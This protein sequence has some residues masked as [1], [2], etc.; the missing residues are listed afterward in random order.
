MTTVFGFGTPN[1]KERLRCWARNRHAHS[2][3][4]GTECMLNGGIVCLSRTCQFRIG[5]Q[6]V[7]WLS[8]RTE[9]CWLQ[10]A[11]HSLRVWDVAKRRQDSP[12]E[13]DA[14]SNICVVAFSL[15][16]RGFGDGGKLTAKSHLWSPRKRELV[17]ALDIEE[18]C[19]ALSFSPEGDLLAAGDGMK[20]R[21]WDLATHTEITTLDGFEVVVNIGRF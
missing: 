16:R 5:A 8:I 14:M 3:V 9:L 2:T 1:A 6:Y 13:L 19:Q 15:I 10:G 18:W 11:L 4:L 12:I 20:I 7:Q 21:M 17:G